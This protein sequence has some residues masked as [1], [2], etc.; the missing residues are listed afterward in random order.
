[1]KKFRKLIPALCMLVVS[2]VLMSATTYAWFSMNTDVNVTGLEIEATAET[3]LLVDDTAK[4]DAAA[5]QAAAKTETDKNTSYAFTIADANKKVKPVAVE[6]ATKNSDL[7]NND[8]W[9]TMAAI[10]ATA[11]TGSGSTKKTVTQ[12]IAADNTLTIANFV[13]IG[14][15]KVTLEKGS[16]DQENGIY[17]TVT[18]KA[19]TENKDITGVTVIIADSSDTKMATFDSTTTEKQQ[20]STTNLTDT[21]VETL[22]IYVYYNGEADAVYTN[23]FAELSGATVSITFSTEAPKA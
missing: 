11:S 20:V 2:A 9:Y 1:M 19:K 12:R 18:L 3:Y 5:I 14:A 15:V 22:N 10:D 7:T 23:N 4:T 6:N 17:A 21:T 8:N 13:Q 16:P